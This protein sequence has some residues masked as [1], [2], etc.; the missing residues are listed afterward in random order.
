MS[1]VRGIEIEKLFYKMGDQGITYFLLSNFN[2]VNREKGDI[3]IFVDLP[4]KN[5]FLGILKS[6]GWLERREPPNLSFHNFYYKIIDDSLIC[7]DVKFQLRFGMS[8]KFVWQAKNE[9]KIITN[10]TKNINGVCR[11]G[12]LNAI[13]LYL[14]HIIKEKP[15]LKDEYFKRLGNYIKLYGEEINNEEKKEFKEVKYLIEQK[16]WEK[17][18]ERY[19]EKKHTRSSPPVKNKIKFGLGYCILFLGTDGSGK[20]TLIKNIEESLNFKIL[21]LYLGEKQWVIPLIGKI[22]HNRKNIRLNFFI[23]YFLY[24]LDLFLR[25][26]KARRWGRYRVILIDRIPGFPFL[27]NNLL[28]WIY[29]VVKPETDLIILLNGSLEKIWERKKGRSLEKTGNDMLKWEK[30][31]SLLAGEKRT[32]DTVLKNHEETRNIVLKAILKDNKFKHR[33]FKPIS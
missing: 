33:L 26:L 17:I 7:L 5:V 10:I 29:S 20:T 1:L 21:K 4:D 13:I 31:Y 11:P 19:F 9:S 28:A 30:V 22:Y 6:L 8:Q 16:R 15:A 3:D 27:G 24:P 18:I 32:I 12:G 23:L 2:D 25:I 14:V